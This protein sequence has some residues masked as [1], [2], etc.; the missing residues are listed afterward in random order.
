M[1]WFESQITLRERG[2]DRNTR[3]TVLTWSASLQKKVME[4]HRRESRKAKQKLARRDKI[5][6]RLLETTGIDVEANAQSD[7]VFCDE[8][9][10]GVKKFL[11]KKV[12]TQDSIAEYV[13]IQSV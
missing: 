7:Y 10:E 1:D 5:I 2:F 12:P 6:N 4:Y 11:Q 9:V 3:Y 8:V 13:F